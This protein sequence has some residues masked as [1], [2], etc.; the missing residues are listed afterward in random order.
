LSFADPAHPKIIRQFSEVTAIG[1]DS[2]RG[3]VFLADPEGMWILR[4]RPAEDPAVVQAYVTTSGAI[5][6]RERFG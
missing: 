2:K 4:E 1:H 5:I 6:D 3:L